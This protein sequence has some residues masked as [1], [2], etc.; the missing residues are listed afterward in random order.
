MFLFRFPTGCDDDDTT[1]CSLSQ[2]AA[3]SDPLFPNY[4][5]IQQIQTSINSIPGNDPADVG[6]EY[7]LSVRSK[8]IAARHIQFVMS[9]HSSFDPALYEL[10]TP[11]IVGYF[12]FP[13][14]MK[15]T[16]LEGMVFETHLY[17]TVTSLAI[18]VPFVFEYDYPPGMFG[19]LGSTVSV[20]DSTTL[21]TFGRTNTSAHF[22]TQEDQCTDEQ[23][24]HT[25]EEWAYTFI[26]G[27]SQSLSTEKQCYVRFSSAIANPTGVPSSTPT[28]TP[29][30][31]PSALP[32]RTPTNSPTVVPTQNPS[33][34]PTLSP[35]LTPTTVPSGT[36]TVTPS[37]IPTALPSAIP[38]VTPSR[39][40]T[41]QPTSLPTSSPTVLPTLLPTVAP[42][43]FPTFLPTTPAPTFMPSY[44]PTLD[45][46]KDEGGKC[47]N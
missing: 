36:P 34:S 8:F 7:F 17:Q 9:P 46:C 22:I 40:P 13:T 4:A 30:Q 35:T 43:I 38:T 29:T 44:S 33:H 25:T 11:E 6:V 47:K 16:C 5:A 19:M 31:F 27:E 24:I 42:T 20:V 23:T 3:R 2:Y 10:D 21:R 26:V 1:S 18:L 14:G 15:E 39:F 32:T 45:V 37:R 12:V 28:T 41:A